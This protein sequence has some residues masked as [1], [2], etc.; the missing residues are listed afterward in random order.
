MLKTFIGAGIDSKL[1]KE[2]ILNVDYDLVLGVI[3]KSEF[4]KRKKYF[5][6]HPDWLTINFLVHFTIQTVKVRARQWRWLHRKFRMQLCTH[7]VQDHIQRAHKCTVAVLNSYCGR[8]AVKTFMWLNIW[9]NACK[10]ASKSLRNS[11][12]FRIN[13]YQNTRRH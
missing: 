10:F 11:S 2:I 4:V 9:K 3:E 6:Q 13:G 5:I 7:V 12:H 8:W 1:K